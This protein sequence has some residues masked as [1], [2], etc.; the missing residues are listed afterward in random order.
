MA[1]FLHVPI[2]VYSLPVP[3]YQIV[4]AAVVV[5]AA[6]FLLIRVRPPAHEQH[7]RSLALP[8]WAPAALSVAAGAFVLF[9][10]WAGIFGRQGLAALNPASL[11]FWTFTV[12]LLPIASCLVGGVYEVANPF[13]AAARLLRG[14][15][16]MPGSD[17]W[18]RRYGYWCSVG[19]MVL[20]V[21]GESISDVVQNP[22]LLG[23]AVA[24]YAAA[25]VALGIVLGDGWYE[26]G[27]L[28]TVLTRMAGCV[29]PTRLE[30]GPPRLKVGF[31]PGRS[32][33]PGPGREALITLWLAGVLADG[34]RATPIWRAVVVPNTQSLFESM[35]KVG[36]VD[37][38]AASEIALEVA[39]TWAAFGAFFWIFT[40]VAARLANAVGSGSAV[41]ARTVAGIVSPSLIPISLAYLLAHNLTQILVVGPL[42]VT[43]RDAEPVE[44]GML[45]QQQIA[46]I[47]P[48]WVWWVQVT[49]IVVGHML[50]VA[51]AHARLSQALGRGRVPDA[52]RSRG[53]EV[54]VAPPSAA[55]LRADLGW[56]S[57]MLIYTATSLWV[58]AQPIAA[59]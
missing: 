26:R 18:I 3:L 13:A 53:G 58:L 22:M 4:L 44:L 14:P 30:S 1:V 43:A 50:A 10:I 7:P 36:G 32:I 46:R 55:V 24:V 48:S 5:V 25:Q 6:S 27:E 15:R 16:R 31:D 12:P 52:K 33:A 59:G 8:P 40:A 28:F 49:A 19:A 37:V 47:S 23:S 11:L 9:L 54:A 20:V 51:M 2:G 45:V 41:T 35:G 38:G 57:A 21:L 17:E 39:V 42:I 34:V 29:A 56:L